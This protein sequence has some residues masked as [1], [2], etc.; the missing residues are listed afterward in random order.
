MTPEQIDAMEAG[1]EL[2]DL[3]GEHVMGFNMSD[4]PHMKE[5]DIRTDEYQLYETTIWSPSTSIADAWDALD[6]FDVVLVRKN[7]DGTYT[8]MIVLPGDESVMRV[9]D[10]TAQLAI[11][12]AALKAVMT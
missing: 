3:V 1:D 9:T 6:K 8:A 5:V 2:D 4:G 12:K 10:K 11:S 7:R